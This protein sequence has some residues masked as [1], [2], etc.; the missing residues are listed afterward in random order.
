M[1]SRFNLEKFLRMPEYFP[2]L[3]YDDETGLFLLDGNYLGFAF[4]ASPLSG[5]DSTIEQRFGA[6]MTADLPAGSYL[7]FNLMVFDDVSEHLA[8]LQANRSK[9]DNPL[10]NRATANTLKFISD[11]ALGKGVNF[12]IR[13]TSLMISLK[14]PIEEA[15]PNEEET[16]HARRLQ[17]EI[18]ESLQTIGYRDLRQVN[19]VELVHQLGIIL[20]RKETASWRTGRFKPDP[21]KFLRESVLDYDNL[22]NVE[23][24]H[25]RIGETYITPMSVKKR[26]RTAYFGLAERFSGDPLNGS[27]GIDCPHMLTCTIKYQDVIEQRP[28][29]ER[30]GQIANYYGQ[31]KY[32]NILGEWQRRAADLDIAKNQI[33]EGDMLHKFTLNLML[34]SNS[35]EEAERNMVS[36]R[37]YLSEIGL[38]FLTDAGITFQMLR[39][40]LPLGTEQEDESNFQRFHTMASSPLATFVP[41]FFDWKGGSE[42]LVSLVSRSGQVMGFNPYESDTNYNFTISAESGA[43]KSFFSNELIS[44]TLG[45][46]GRV[47]VIDVGRSYQKLCDS[48]D[49]QFLSF[50]DKSNICLNPFSSLKTDKD[51]EEVQDI[52]LS[53]LSSM[54]APKKGLDD[55]QTAILREVTRAQFHEHREHL[56]I[57]DIAKACLIE[58]QEQADGESGEFKEK[59]ISDIAHGLRAFCSDGQY[60]RYFNGPANINFEKNF[61]LLEL[62]ELKSQ[63]HLQQIV[64]LLLIYQIQQGMYMGERDMRKLMLID[65]AWD[66]LADPQIE[67]FI[68]AG[69]RRFRK[70]NGSAG[71]ITQALTDLH[72]SS[73]GKAIL[74]NSA[75]TIMLAQKDATLNR[76][77]QGENA[78]LSNALAQRLKTVHTKKGHY[79][80]VYVANSYGG[81]IGKLAVDPYRALLY[82]THPDDV[83]AIER[84]TR[85][86]IETGEAILKVLSDRQESVL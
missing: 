57:D 79:S 80:E 71:I 33:T 5:F 15:V 19:D 32:G 56:K 35:K 13:N 30:K 77:A 60:G 2:W 4:L 74:A 73:T 47:W 55:F 7:Q 65:E 27:R 6:L 81:G 62:E 14:I 50:D 17:R 25:V 11:G 48:L 16:D 52:I 85:Q 49:G 31:G 10:V 51:F 69:Y 45:A 28:K 3:G 61:V 38:T 72:D 67:S 39:A 34:F 1:L 58:A 59:R 84:Y 21:N 18:Q 29:I 9:S 68:E 83:S 44:A 40:N 78:E 12:P 76:L 43:G 37:T 20:N 86:G 41:T 53:L 64:L 36:A 26:P 82:S 22:I 8:R 63:K 46:G 24:Q 70:Y 75:T 23:R 42:P 54:A 66:L